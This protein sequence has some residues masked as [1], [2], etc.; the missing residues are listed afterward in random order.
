MIFPY[1]HKAVNVDKEILK[2]YT[3]SYNGVNTK[4]DI[5]YK[6]GKLY[7]DYESRPDIEL[8]PESETKFFYE[9]G[10][11]LQIEFQTGPDYNI[12]KI[13]LISGGLKTEL[14]KN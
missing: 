12:E 14:K 9:D 8:I 6:E 1:V 5:I 2:K 11:D 13:W 4:I 3:G 7:R 10:R